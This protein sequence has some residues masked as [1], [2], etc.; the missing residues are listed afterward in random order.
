MGHGALSALSSL[1]AHGPMR[2]GALAEIEGV[3]AP[4]MTRIVTSL[5]RLAAVR[6]TTDPVDGRAF[7]VQPTARGRRQVEAGRAARMQALRRRL[8]GLAPGDR[9]L[10][11][12]AVPA[13]EALAARE[14]GQ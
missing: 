11:I 5:E 2:L 1:V 10:V 12:A 4:S 9:T 7:L 6:R 14:P 8:D 13:L 3:S